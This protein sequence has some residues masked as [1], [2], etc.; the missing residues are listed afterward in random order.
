[1]RLLLVATV[2]SIFTFCNANFHISRVFSGTRTVKYLACPLNYWNCDCYISE[3]RAGHVSNQ[4]TD[5]FSIDGMCGV[6]QMNLYKDNNADTLSM[7][8]NGGD[9]QVIGRCYRNTAER[10]CRVG[11]SSPGLAVVNDEWVCYTYVCE[12]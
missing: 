12:P 3:D 7:Y 11:G 2:V 5:N 9:G 10:I 1:M 8:H 4:A 6:G